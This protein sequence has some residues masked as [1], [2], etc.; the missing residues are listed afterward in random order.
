MQKICTIRKK[1]HQ[2]QDLRKFAKFVVRL[3]FCVF[4]VYVYLK[5]RKQR[6]SKSAHFREF[7]K[8]FSHVWETSEY[9]QIITK[10]P[11]KYYTVNLNLNIIIWLYRM[12]LFD[13]HYT[14]SYFSYLQ[15]PDIMIDGV[16]LHEHDQFN[17][18]WLIIK[19]DDQLHNKETTAI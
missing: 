9:L 3:Y 19:Y 5:N 8:I 1:L 12:K 13:E 17:I 14:Y 4:F 16:C 18:W 7:S 10:P 2:L 15:T 11:P 6:T